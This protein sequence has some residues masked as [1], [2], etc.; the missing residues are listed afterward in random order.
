[1]P[2]KRGLMV[3]RRND[4]LD[5]NDVRA[6][7]QQLEEGMLAV[8]SRL[9]PDERAGRGSY[10]LAVE[11][12]ALAVRFHVKLL[13]IGRQTG[14]ALVI[15]D[16]G[17]RRISADHAMPETDEAEKHR[18]VLLE[19]R[20]PE[21]LVER[22]GAGE[23]VFE[24][25]CS[26]GDHDR[27]A[28]RRPQ[29]IATADP[30]PEAEDAV[31]ADAEGGD[32]VERGRD[33]GEVIGDRRLAKSGRQPG[34]GGRRIGHRLDGREGLR[35]DDEQRRGG[36]ETGERVGDM[37]SVDIGDVVGARAVVKGRK[38]QGGHDGS[39][40]GAADA[41]VDDVGDRLAGGTADRAG[42]D[43]VGVAA[44]GVEH[45]ANLRHDVGAIDADRPVGPVAQGDVQ[46]GAVFGRVDA[47]AGKH[48]VAALL[49]AGRFRERSEEPHRLDVDRAFG[50]VDRQIVQRGGVAIGAARIDGEDVAHRHGRSFGAMA[51]ERVEGRFEGVAVHGRS[52]VLRCA[53]PRG[54]RPDEGQ[55]ASAAT[56]A[57]I[58]QRHEL[59]RSNNFIGAK[60]WTRL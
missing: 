13:E 21:M 59:V 8:G 28:D 56:R 38:R 20:G 46:H 58:D 32:L 51:A 37:R 60:D 5:R 25:V 31:L 40:I 24:I 23:H 35:G 9:A 42:A 4:E 50:E 27:E 48:G 44:H 41:D 6:L 19:R 36:I 34:A 12:D 10:G 18:Q 55:S 29:R 53:E 57:V 14:E 16:D 22:M 54:H 43:T 11:G 26:D 33:R 30:V 15:R 45:G 49:D 3:L 7:V 2:A 52:I 1:M 39:E 47:R 17:A